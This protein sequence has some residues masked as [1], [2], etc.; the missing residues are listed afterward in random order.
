MGSTNMQHS[1]HPDMHNNP[2]HRALRQLQ[3]ASEGADFAPDFVE[4]LLHPDRTVE[5]AV[6]VV[7]DDKTLKVFD[8]YRVQ[9]NNT[10][11]PYKGGI[12]YHAHVDMDDVK[13]LSFWMTIKNAVVDIPFGGGKGG[14]AVDPKTVTPAELE[15]LTREFARKLAPVIGPEGDV[16]GPDVGTNAQV[17]DW[18]ADEYVHDTARVPHDSYE[19]S[20]AVVTGK[21][22]EKGGSEGRVE[23]TG[24]GGGYVLM[25]IWKLM[26]IDPK[27]KRV[28]IQG[29]GNV[30]SYVAQH[31]A[32]AGCAIVA[33]CDSK[34]GIYD[35]EGLDL[36]SAMHYKETYGTFAGFNGRLIEPG[37]ILTMPADVV[38]PA[39]LENSVTEEV[40]EA[41]QAK[42]VL[43]LANGPTT[44]DA[45]RILNERGIIVIPDVLANAGGVATSY[46][47]WRQNL[48]GEHWSKADVLHK[49]EE[50]MRAASGEVFHYAH[51]HHIP[52]RKAAYQIALRRI[53]EA[54]G[55]AA[56]ER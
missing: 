30:G 9:Y 45:D 36:A 15:R 17:M 35:P 33:V 5:V 56:R 46:F 55:D 4:R 6:P 25:E 27:G 32:E 23:A 3:W 8:G 20:R 21:P 38:I 43:E 44:N 7:M 41:I 54:M 28:A 42:I 2:W 12:R 22:I 49:L 11:G 31:L 50:K 39:A 37:D 29:F 10:R 24:Y 52:L 26:D 53:E 16:P 48:G 14:V 47:E 19:H 34:N 1:T 40:A 18:I 51:E 13:A